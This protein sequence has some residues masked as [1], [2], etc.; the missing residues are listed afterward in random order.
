MIGSIDLNF[1]KVEMCICDE[2]GDVLLYIWFP[3]KKD[4][5]GKVL[6][7]YS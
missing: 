3:L 4:D 6:V 7:G 1:T 5:L 2:M